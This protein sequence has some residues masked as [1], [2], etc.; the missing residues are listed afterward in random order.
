MDG[1]LLEPQT[2]VTVTQADMT[3]A[4]AQYRLGQ[5]WTSGGDLLLTK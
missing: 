3:A 5:G 1:R 2:L 4:I